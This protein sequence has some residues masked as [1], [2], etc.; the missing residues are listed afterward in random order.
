MQDLYKKLGLVKKYQ[1]KYCK[2]NGLD[3]AVI[4]DDPDKIPPPPPIKQGLCKKIELKVD[5]IEDN[6]IDLKEKV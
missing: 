2:E 6:I 3:K 1:K 5:E 4:K